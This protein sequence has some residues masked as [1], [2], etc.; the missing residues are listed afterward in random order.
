M[1]KEPTDMPKKTGAAPAADVTDPAAAPA[2]EPVVDLAGLRAVVKVPLTG[3]PDGKVYP[4][5]FAEG[6]VVEGNL[7]AVALREG[8][9]EVAG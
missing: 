7:A 6:D 4:R 3:A 1:Q 2:A 9:A 5:D 8:W